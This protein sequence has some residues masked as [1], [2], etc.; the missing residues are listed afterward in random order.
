MLYTYQRKLLF[1]SIVRSWNMQASEWVE[2]N[3]PPVTISV[4]SEADLK[5]ANSVWNPYTMQL[6][7]DFVKVQ[8]RAI[9]FVTTLKRFRYRQRLERRIKKYHAYSIIRYICLGITRTDKL[10]TVALGNC[11]QNCFIVTVSP[12]MLQPVNSFRIPYYEQTDN[13]IW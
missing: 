2:F 1:H 5:Y 13:Y 9:K 3:A 8:M 6:I 12:S 7:K 10:M 4:I 11:H